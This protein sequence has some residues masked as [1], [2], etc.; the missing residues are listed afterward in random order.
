MTIRRA[1]RAATLL[2]AI[3]ALAAVPADAQPFERIATDVGATGLSVTNVGTLGRPGVAGD[4]GG[5]PSFEYPLDSGVEHLF[6]AGLW[7]G[8]RRADGVVTVR[9]GAVTTSGGKRSFTTRPGLP[10]TT[11]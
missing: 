7:V 1:A 10:T 5:L 3:A 11:A 9:T 8:G 4:P 6:E 2:A